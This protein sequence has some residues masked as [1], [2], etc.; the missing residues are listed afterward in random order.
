MLVKICGIT[1]A[2]G[3]RGRG[4]ARRRRARLRVLAG[5]PALRRSVSRAGDR[6]DAAAVRHAGRRVRRTSRV[7]HV[8]GVASAGRGSAPCSCTATRP[9]EYAA[10]L[11]APVI[12]AVPLDR[13]SASAIARRGRDATMLLLDA[14]DPVQRGGTGPDGRLGAAAP[15]AARAADRAGRR[16]DAGQRRRR[17]RAGAA[18]RHRRVVGR[19]IVA[20]RQGSRRGCAR[21]FEA[22]H[23]MDEHD[24]IGRRDPDARGYFGE[25]GGRFVPETLVAPVEELE[26]AYLAARDE[27]RFAPSSIACSQHYVGRPTP[28]YEATRLRGRRRRRAHLPEARGPDAHRRAQDQQRARPGA[29]RRAHGQAAHRRRDRRRPAR[30]RHR[31]RL[32]AARPR[33]RRLHGR[34]GHG[35]PGAER[36]P[37]AAAR[38]RG[39]PRRR[40]AAAR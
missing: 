25:F 2:R 19:R 39:L 8:N 5:Q 31:D 32:R 3:C 29:A 37:H 40:R 34:R 15:I 18:V 30:R 11:S 33:V 36:L 21:L 13:R 20:R 14:H 12:K 16:A 23:D 22:L 35:A 24:D 6:R 28:V 7:E 27:P 1:R 17:G 38:R 9:P 26:R 10:Q 4:R